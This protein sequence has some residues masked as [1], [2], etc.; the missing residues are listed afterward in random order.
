MIS[1]IGRLRK[2]IWLDAL[3]I[4]LTVLSLIGAVRQVSLDLTPFNLIS[5]NHGLITLGAI[6]VLM[7]GL[8]IIFHSFIPPLLLVPL[9]LIST[10]NTLP[11]AAWL[12]FISASVLLGFWLTR[13]IAWLRPL[14]LTL[15]EIGA[16][17]VV[18]FAANSCVVWV[19]MHFS[20]NYTPVYWAFFLAEAAVFGRSLGNSRPQ[21]LIAAT[22]GRWF[23]L[24]FTLFVLPYAVVPAYNFD[25]LSSH[26]FI[27]QQ[28]K[29]FGSFEFSPH[30]AM[31]LTPCLLSIGSY[32]SVFLLG[33]ENAV[34]LL[35]VSLF[36]FSALALESGTRRFWS[37]RTAL[38]ATLFSVFTPFTCWILGIVFVDSFFLLFATMLLFYSLAVAREKP[39]D[40]LP[41]CGLL[42][43]LGY[44]AK[45]QIIFFLLPL[46]APLA[47][48]AF[49]LIWQQPRT[50]LKQLLAAVIVFATTISPPLL[51]NYLLS[52]NPIYPFYNAFF[53]SSYWPAENLKDSRWSQPL[54]LSSLWN[55]TFNGPLFIE[56]MRYAFG[57]SALV[58]APLLLVRCTGDAIKRNFTLCFL[59]CCAIAYCYVCYKMTGL[60]MRYLVGVTVPLSVAL[61]IVV[62]DVSARSRLARWIILGVLGVVLSGNLA[63]FLSIRNGADPYPIYAALTGSV[64][65]SSMVY[66]ANFK[67]LFRKASKKFGKDSL[68]LLV[69]TPANYFGETRITSNYWF[70]PTMS[71]ALR[72]RVT[73]NDLFD[74]IFHETRAHYIIMPLSGA[75]GAF[76]D[77]SF[78]S[79]LALRSKTVDFGLFVPRKGPE[80]E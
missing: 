13:Q 55:L 76:S 5:I 62:S 11:L 10:G 73:A 44:L 64:E 9:F 32:T 4:F 42:F 22:P 3:G 17:F 49:R 59:T 34:R 71:A 26:L 28:T 21:F 56:N 15:T 60:Y 50:G 61:A 57:F 53:R 7:L 16:S 67:K 47:C 35:N 40:W 48:L 27:P 12:T 38:F 77:R 2:P 19:A 69:E 74:F 31:G 37:A 1:I 68:G 80:A 24:G 54:D 46:S 66:H 8:R 39:L 58:F 36:V 63:A 70:F 43:G 6:S 78:Q 79:R 18:G 23:I 65:E 51:H 75:P 25:D 30:F 52:G 29:L 41:S 45:Q 33:G 72:E 20:V 14:R